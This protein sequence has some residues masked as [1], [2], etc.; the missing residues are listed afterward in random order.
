MTK[1]ERNLYTNSFRGFILFIMIFN[2]LPGSWQRYTYETFGYVSVAE[3]FIFL[4]D[5][6][7]N[8]VIH[9]GDVSIMALAIGS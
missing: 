1:S 8:I 2:H 7:K 9:G 5:N 4:S 6:A 3:F